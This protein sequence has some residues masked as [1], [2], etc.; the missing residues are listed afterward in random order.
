[1]PVFGNRRDVTRYETQCLFKGVKAPPESVTSFSKFGGQL[2]RETSVDAK[3]DGG[4]CSQCRNSPGPIKKGLD[5]DDTNAYGMGKYL[6]CQSDRLQANRK[7][8]NP[9]VALAEG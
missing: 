9:R 6:T 3:S 4:S 8:P 2:C 1:M 5:Y 7:Q